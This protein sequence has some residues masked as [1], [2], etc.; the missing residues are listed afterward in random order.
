VMKAILRVAVLLAS[1]AA[2]AAAGAA[3][4]RAASPAPGLIGGT[5]SASAH[6]VALTSTA[7][8]PVHVELTTDRP[9]SFSPSAFDIKPGETIASTVTGDASGSV[10][11]H[12]SA[13][14]TSARDSST[15]TLQVGFPKPVTP[16]FPWGAVGGALVTA[17]VVLRGLVALRRVSRHYTLVRK[18][19]PPA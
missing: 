3:S 6:E 14:T 2:I 15:V 4:V 13:L 18:S 8:M 11:A 16:A 19:E 10:S 5:L 1:V 17:L 12:L 9:A 7:T